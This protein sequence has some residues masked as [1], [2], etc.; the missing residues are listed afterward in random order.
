LYS[1]GGVGENER[2]ETETNDVEVIV[3]VVDLAGLELLEEEALGSLDHRQNPWVAGGIAVGCGA[4]SS[5]QRIGVSTAPAPKSA[6]KC[7]W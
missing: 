7:A 1:D 6:N 5:R 2:G 4:R 3:L